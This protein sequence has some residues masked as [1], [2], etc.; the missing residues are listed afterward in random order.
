MGIQEDVRRFLNSR[1]VADHFESIGYEFNALEAAWVVSRSRLATVR[2]RHE[3]W[4]RIADELPDMP[5]PGLLGRRQGSVRGSLD[6]VIETELDL[7]RE[8][9]SPGSGASFSYMVRSRRSCRSYGEPCS[10]FAECWRSALDEVGRSADSTSGVYGAAME[11]HRKVGYDEDRLWA[12]L[13]KDGKLTSTDWLIKRGESSKS[14]GVIARARVILPVPFEEGD[15]VFGEECGPMVVADMSGEV[16]QETLDRV[17]IGGVLR[18]GYIMHGDEVWMESDVS[19][20]LVDFERCAPGM[21]VGDEVKLLQVG[22]LVR[23]GVDS[24]SILSSSSADQLR[25]LCG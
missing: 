11:M 8:F 6:Y 22:E 21:L 3:M 19:G 16:P 23:R 17:G 10:S 5:A 14:N 9:V 13:R 18:G 25:S 2:E 20:Q 24:D 12:R 7:L 1:D 4:R 15:L